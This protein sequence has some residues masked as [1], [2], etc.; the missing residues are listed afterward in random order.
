MNGRLE[1]K[2]KNEGYVKRHL[3]DLP[4]C[5]S[6][7]YYSRSSSKESKGSAEYIKKIKSFLSFINQDTKSID[8][9]KITEDDVSKYLHGIEQTI[10]NNG[11]IRETTFAYRKQVHSILN[12]FFEYLRKRRIIAENPM[13]CI[14]RPVSKDIVKRK[15]LDSFD[16]QFL[17]ESV[18]KGAG[19]DI[20]KNRQKNWKLRDKAIII[21]LAM[22]G[23]RETALLEINMDDLNFDDGTIKVIDKRHKTHIYKMNESMRNALMNWISD[24]ALKLSGENIDALFISNRKQR[25][26]TKSLVAIVE[27]YSLEGLGYKISPHKLRAAFCTILYKKTGDIEFVRRA[28][29]HSSI[30]TTQRYIVDDDTAKDEA[31]LIMEKMFGQ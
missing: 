31:A 8:V 11:N 17:L 18:D 19:S 20:Q 30:E 4:E 24:R 29:G 23:M 15:Y 22:T 6:Q 10:D 7:Y 28:V 27:K 16:I 2:V 9:S 13:D 26:G 1:H 12:S 21:L 25:L 5:V 3:N 14:E